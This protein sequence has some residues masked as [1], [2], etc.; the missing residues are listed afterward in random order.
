MAADAVPQEQL[1]VSETTV[2]ETLATREAEWTQRKLAQHTGYSIGLINTILKKLSRTGYI[3]I[4]N[5]NSRRLQYLLTPQGLAATSRVACNYILRTFHDY[6]RLYVQ[7][8]DFF[9]DLSAKGHQN[10]CVTCEDPELAKLVHVVIRDCGLSSKIN[11]GDCGDHQITKVRLQGA[12]VTGS[13]PILNMA[14]VQAS[15]GGES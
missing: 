5:L 8:S 6:Q 4:A 12:T 2:L 10:L 13:G 1:L 7:I 15:D 14:V 3:K 9:Q 11:F